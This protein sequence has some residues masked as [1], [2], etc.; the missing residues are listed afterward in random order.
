MSADIS[1]TLDTATEG[2]D[3]TGFTLRL[4][5]NNAAMEGSEV[6]RILRAVADRMEGE[7][8]AYSRNT[9]SSLGEVN[10]NTVGFYALTTDDEPLG[11]WPGGGP[12]EAGDL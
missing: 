5:L 10:G 8:F 1:K 7:D 11:R 4:D 9:Y 3:L 6:A 2:E 12:V